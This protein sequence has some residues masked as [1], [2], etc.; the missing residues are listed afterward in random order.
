MHRSNALLDWFQNRTKRQGRI[1]KFWIIDY[2]DFLLDFQRVL[3]Y[4]GIHLLGKFS[5]GQ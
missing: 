1:K 4:A 3:S 2:D 5:Q